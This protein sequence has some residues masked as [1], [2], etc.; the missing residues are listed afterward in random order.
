MFFCAAEIGGFTGPLVVGAL[1]DMTGTF[2]S[3]IAFL[4]VLYVVTFAMKFL[5]H[6]QPI[7]TQQ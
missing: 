3:G 7:A 6:S 5:L 2:L 1:L 4:A